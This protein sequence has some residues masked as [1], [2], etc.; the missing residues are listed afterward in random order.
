[1]INETNMAKYFWEEAVNT[2]CYIHNRVF[3]RLILCKTPYEL[4]KKKKPNISYFHTFGCS[5]F[6]M[7]TKENL[8]KFAS[9]AQSCIP[10]G[11]SERS[12]GYNV[13]N[14]ENTYC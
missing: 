10:L 1:M 2:A 4:W 8:N 14:N 7:N 12:K 5:C 3:I 11:Y 9:K 13:Y 6:I